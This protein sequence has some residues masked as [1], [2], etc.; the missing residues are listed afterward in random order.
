MGV[1]VVLSPQETVSKP[2][3]DLFPTILGF[4][5]RQVGLAD[6][7]S[8]RIRAQVLLP[9]SHAKADSIWQWVKAAKTLSGQRLLVIFLF[10]IDLSAPKVS[11]S[12]LP[13]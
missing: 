3:F 2:A 6:G 5:S 9:A 4:L 12:A 13:T 10:S 8:A 7:H 11:Q 1:N